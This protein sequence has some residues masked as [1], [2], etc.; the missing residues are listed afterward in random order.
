MKPFNGIVLTDTFNLNKKGE[1]PTL[2]PKEWLPD[3]N[4][5]AEHQQKLPIQVIVGN[6]PWSG[7]QRSAADD[8]PNV[9]YPVLA[10][11]IAE[12]YA[13][14]STVTNKNS[15][16]DTYKMAIRWAS[17]RIEEQGIVAFVTN[18]SWIDGNVDA[19]IRACLADEF[20]S[21][22]VLHLRGNARTSGELRRSEGDNVFGLGSRAPV[23]ITIL[24]KNP[25]AAQDRCRILYRDIGDYLKREEKFTILRES[26]LISG[27]NDWQE[28]TPDEHHDWIGQR[29]AAFANF[30]PLGSKDVKAG[31]VDDA[32]FRLYSQGLNTSR[33]PYIYNFSQE[34]CKENAQRMVQDY[35]AA[36]VEKEA[37][38]PQ[39]TEDEAAR[40]HS[41][42]IKWNREP[43]N[44]LRR[45][46]KNEFDEKFIRKAAYRPFIPTNCYADYIFVAMK[47]Q[48]DQ[49]FPNSSS[50]NRVICVPSIGSQKP[51]SALMTDTMTDLN[52]NEAGARCFPRYQYQEPPET[53]D[54]TDSLPG[55]EEAP[56]RIDNISDTALRTFRECYP[57]NAITKNAIFDY[58]YGI[59]HLPSYRE[60]FAN[61]LSKEIP[62]I[63][64]APDFC[65]FAE[66]GAALAA[67]HLGYE[68]CEQYPL[69]VV[70]AHGEE[71][72]PHHFHLTEK[73]MRF[74]TSAKTTLVINEHVRLTG[75]PEAAHRYVV[76]GR[77]P[78][79]W[80]IDRY[81]IKRDKESGI[82]ND[83]NGW[84]ADP[85]DLI[86]AIKRIVYVSVESTRII[87]NLPSQ[88]ID[89]TQA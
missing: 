74:A 24:V 33:D 10:Q 49:I 66:A 28:I 11:R 38:N 88:L 71:P 51:F 36:I 81:K 3:N 15:L 47:Y 32:I 82:L 57:D 42:N 61:D 39:L 64:F 56:N 1:V 26:A 48:I 7:K 23:A 43:Q 67:L 62:R 5:R 83:P 53:P 41:S 89:D 54:T 8:N 68:T 17:D 29:S 34:A 20:S 79:E 14:R 31:G 18:G 25:N 63:P 16:Y 86:T 58:V 35:L 77:T 50:E 37:N 70:F 75:I 4:A 52:L 65:A 19:G 84:F 46:I 72:Q 13:T 80:F 59:L 45:K 87:E 12:T 2:F 9:K 6:P 60:E 21:I 73:A 76:N 30:Y 69:S 22:Y 40:R 44:N 27:F 85:R 78:L 55:I